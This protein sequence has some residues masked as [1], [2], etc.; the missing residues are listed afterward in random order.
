MNQLSRLL[1][2]R[3]YQYP[4]FRWTADRFGESNEF[5]GGIFLHD[6]NCMTDVIDQ[7]VLRLRH[8]C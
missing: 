6:G 1:W 8:D 3:G 7:Q 4:G 5:L 2:E